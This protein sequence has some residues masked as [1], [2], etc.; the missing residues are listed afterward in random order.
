MRRRRKEVK[1]RKEGRRPREVPGR[2]ESQDSRN[3]TR[4]WRKKRTGGGM[5]ESSD[6]RVEG[7]EPKKIPADVELEVNGDMTV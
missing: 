3:G 2:R 5:N 4:G 6:V 1:E 7:V